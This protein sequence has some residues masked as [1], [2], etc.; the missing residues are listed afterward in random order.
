MMVRKLVVVFFTVFC[1]AGLSATAADNTPKESIRS[2]VDAVLAVMKDKAMS[3][4]GKKQ[5]RRDRIRTLIRERF[6]FIEMS[7]RSLAKHWKARNPEERKEFVAI[8]SELLEAS[9]IGKIELYTNEKV[10]YDKETLKGKGK[11]GVVSTTIV[12]Q[13]VDIP[14]E[15]KVISKK[16]KWWV[17]DVVIEGVSF[18]STYRSQYNKIIVRKSYADLI[19]SMKDKLNEI[20]ESESKESS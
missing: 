16:D 7:K 6:D 9:Y 15:Y 2:T 14:I 8:F 13:D 20:N 18:I 4:A 19:E 17:Y 3:V 1:F 10:T 12:T 11:Y 5:E